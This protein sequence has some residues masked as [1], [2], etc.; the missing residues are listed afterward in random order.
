ML[1]KIEGRR[2]RGWQRMRWLDGITNSMDVSLSE[3]RELMMD[4]EAW[5][6]AIHG[7]AKCRTRLS[8][9]TELISM[10][11]LGE[12]HWLNCPPWPGSI[13]TIGMSYFTVGSPG[14][15]HGLNKPPPTGRVWERSKGNVNV[16][17]HLPE[18]L[19]SGIHLG[20]R[21]APPGRTLSQ[22]DWPKTT[23]KLMWSP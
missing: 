9:W 21:C 11:L 15:E 17:Y 8:N 23:W 2:K 22:S 19:L 7:I 5:R 18:I 10:K 12:A 14:K 6:A 20:T 16:S 1:G 13:V 3:L 4:R